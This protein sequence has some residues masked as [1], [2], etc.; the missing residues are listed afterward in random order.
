[1]RAVL[2]AIFIVACSDKSG[3]DTA[4]VTET[5][6]CADAPVVT[7]NSFGEGFL[8]ENCQ[9][10]HAST[11][12]DRHDAPEE[13]VFDTLEDALANADRILARATGDDPTM[14]PEGGVDEDDR[15]RL[16]IWLTC[17]RE[18]I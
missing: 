16:E 11:A 2:L 7:W 4:P 1:M 14:P 10:C 13:T 12:P 9:S 8:R 15:A 6:P 3:D 17:W 5:G 18:E